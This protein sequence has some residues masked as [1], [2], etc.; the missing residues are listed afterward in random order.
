[1]SHSFS[2]GLVSSTVRVT[3]AKSQKDVG[4]ADIHRFDQILIGLFV[5]SKILIDPKFKRASASVELCGL[6]DS[7]SRDCATTCF[8]FSSF[9]RSSPIVQVILSSSSI[10]IESST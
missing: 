7:F 9:Q 3:S 1:M 6:L 5:D 2:F 8:V 10:I 4:V